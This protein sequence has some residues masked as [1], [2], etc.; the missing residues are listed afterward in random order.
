MKETEMNDYGTVTY[1]GR[2]LKLQ[3]AAAID[4]PIDGPASYYA[5]GEDSDGNLYEV[6]WDIIS[7]CVDGDESGACDWDHPAS[8]TPG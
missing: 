7:E 8:I 2:T 4:G 5:I 6:R 1:E 3:G